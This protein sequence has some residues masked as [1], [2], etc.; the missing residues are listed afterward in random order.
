MFY[1]S[2]WLLQQHTAV[3]TVAESYYFGS[4]FAVYCLFCE[5]FSQEGV[6]FTFPL[7]VLNLKVILL[8][9]GVGNSRFN[10]RDAIIVTR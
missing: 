1:V 9:K 4:I 8:F 10:Y 2:R 3:D 5:E 6:F 7:H